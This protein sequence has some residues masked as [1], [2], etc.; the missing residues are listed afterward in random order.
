MR[1]TRP[2][3]IGISAN[4][5]PGD[6]DRA[7]YRG[8]RL[9]YAE[10]GLLDWILEAGGLPVILPLYDDPAINEHYLDRLDGLIM[11]GGG[12]VAPGAYGQEARRP[13]WE[14]EPDR[15]L[16]E[17]ALL[18]QALDRDMPVFGVCRGF[19]VLNVHFGGSLHQDLVDGG[20]SRVVHKDSILYDGIAHPLE[21]LPNNWLADVYAEGSALTNSVH[22]QGIDRLADG[23]EVMATCPDDGL[24]EAVRHPDYRLVV[25][26]QWHPEWADDTA[27]SK[28]VLPGATMGR[29]FVDFCRDRSE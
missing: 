14:G 2:P 9:E 4:L 18:K 20:L 7:S 26:V 1:E 13:E 11:A 24:V 28:G 21:I 17:F 5:E 16:G 27:A 15:D 23:L 10:R 29:A 25:G 6:P 19:Q 8:K 12:D 3:L 22:H